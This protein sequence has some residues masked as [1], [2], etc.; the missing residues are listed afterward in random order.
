MKLAEGTIHAR[1]EFKQYIEISVPNWRLYTFEREVNN[2]LAPFTAFMESL[3]NNQGM[4]KENIE[5]IMHIFNTGLISSVTQ[6]TQEEQV[7]HLQNI[8]N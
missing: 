3:I 8:I 7:T 4:N 6:K 1:S 5:N 2:H